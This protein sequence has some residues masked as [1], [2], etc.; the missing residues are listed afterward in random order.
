MNLIKDEKCFYFVRSYRVT[1]TSFKER[2]VH[3]T[4]ETSNTPNK[5]IA[6]S[7][8]SIYVNSKKLIYC[9][10]LNRVLLQNCHQKHN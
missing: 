2:F 10:L 3:H 1:E 8:E 6:P 4:R 9:Q 7:Y 5:E